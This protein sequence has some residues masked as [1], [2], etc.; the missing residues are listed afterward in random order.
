MKLATSR[1]KK[2]KFVIFAVTMLA[3]SLI[4][5]GCSKSST[6][7]SNSDGNSNSSSTS[8]Q[9]KNLSG[10]VKIDGSSTVGPISEA[11]AEEFM[12]ANPGVKVSVGISGTG[13]GFKKFTQGEI[14]ISD[15][16]RQIKPEEKAIA[17]KNGISYVEIPVA[18][19]GI[20]MVINKENTWAKSITTAELKK[21]WE[22]GSKINNWNQ[23]NPAYPNQTLKLYGPGTDSGTFD[24]FTKEING[25]EK[26]SRTDYAASEDDNTLVTGVAGDKGSLGYFGY[27]Y[28]KENEDKLGLLAV[29]GGNGAIT[30][31]EE[32]IKNDTY[33]PLSR[34]IF[35]YVNKKALDKPEVKEFVKFY[36]SDGRQLVSDVG[37]VQLDKAEYEKYLALVK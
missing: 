10:S 29:D 24:Y 28:Y 22:P 31:S 6:S 17:D 13:G 21:I 18:Y 33:K 19:D 3:V 8:E 12:N 5:A 35:I 23:V 2:Q 20:S 27:A 36:L 16:S 26:A 9:S 1:T 30:P 15:A 11:V 25:E 14:D 34:K 4:A 7:Q 37:Y 32:T